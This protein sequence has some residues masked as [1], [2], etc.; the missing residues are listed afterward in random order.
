MV[1]LTFR[2]ETACKRQTREKGFRSTVKKLLVGN[3]FCLF[4]QMEVNRGFTDLIC[5]SKKGG[6]DQESIQSSITPDPG[7]HMGK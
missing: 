3:C 1:K 4:F 2:V 5:K 7:Y 6:K